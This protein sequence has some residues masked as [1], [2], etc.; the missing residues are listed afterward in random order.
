MPVKDYCRRPAVEMEPEASVREAARRMEEEGLG[1]LLVAEPGGPAGVVTDR[2]LALEIY[3][4]KLDPDSVR[5]R[6]I[7]RTDLVTVREDAPLAEAARVMRRHGLRRLPVVDAGGKPVGV[8]A[9][10]DLLQV[11]VGELAGLAVAI[12]AQTPAA[13]ERS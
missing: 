5:L 9:A 8:I 13:V 1:C 4:R 3:C 2:D 10:D 11:V 7:A 6:E 12:R